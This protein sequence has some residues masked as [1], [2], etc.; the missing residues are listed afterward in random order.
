MNIE[1][2]IPL[3]CFWQTISREIVKYHLPAISNNIVAFIHSISFIAHYN[4]EY[5]LEYAV[6]LSIGYYIHDLIY[7]FSKVYGSRENTKYDRY[8]GYD[9]E[10]NK[11]IPYII[12][13]ILGMSILYGALTGESR[14]HILGGYNI[15]EKSNIMLYISYY[16]HK[17]YS[18]YQRIIIISDFIQLLVYS[19]YRLVGLSLFIYHHNDV[20]VQFHLMT[21]LFI[22]A[23]YGMGVVWS[24]RLVKQNI[25]NIYALQR[26]LTTSRKYSSAG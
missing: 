10:I 3:I 6:H 22:V 26:W 5:N 25:S 17:K 19:Y 12:H 13:H 16:L 21:Q 20:F 23:I 15:I 18:N 1:Y 2:I 4:Y 24:Y 8:R 11:Y 7:I 14:E 9:Y